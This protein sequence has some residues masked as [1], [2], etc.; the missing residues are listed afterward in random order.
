MHAVTTRASRTTRMVTVLALVSGMIA[1]TPPVGAKDRGWPSTRC[2]LSDA[3]AKAGP[4]AGGCRDG[5]AHG[6]GAARVGPGPSVFSGRAMHG[7][8]VSGVTVEQTGDWRLVTDRSVRAPVGMDQEAL[9]SE[10]AY[11]DAM[12]G[13]AAAS[14]AYRSTGNAASSR[15]YADLGRKLADGRPE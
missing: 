6:Y 3:R 13:A 15:Y 2:R 5:V 1:T 14:T 10:T 11:R 4:W 12:R 7:R 8:A 9:W